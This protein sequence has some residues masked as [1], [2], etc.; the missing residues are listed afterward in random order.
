MKKKLIQKLQQLV[1][2][3]PLGNKKKKLSM[4]Y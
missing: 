2:E 4:T 3:L 1:D